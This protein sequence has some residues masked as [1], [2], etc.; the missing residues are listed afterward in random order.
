MFFMPL[1]VPA[2]WKFLSIGF[3]AQ[4]YCKILKATIKTDAF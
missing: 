4:C 1:S 3:L 2:L